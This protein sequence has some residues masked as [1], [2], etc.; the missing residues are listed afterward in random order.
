MRA[1]LRFLMA[2]AMGFASGLLC[3]AIVQ[4]A[5]PAAHEIT[6]QMAFVAAF[7][8]TTLA[9]LITFSRQEG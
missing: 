5:D 6:L 4:F 3:A 9:C 8:L 1:L 7:A 2:S